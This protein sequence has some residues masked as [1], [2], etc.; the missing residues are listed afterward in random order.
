MHTGKGQVLELILQDG[1]RYARLACPSNLIPSAGQYLLASEG[2]DVSLPFSLFYTD[3]A[4]Q[5]FIAECPLTAPW[6][7]G[8]VLYLRGPLGRGFSL[9]LSAR[10]VGLVAFDHSPARLQGLV[11]PALNQGAAVVL[12]SGST[13]DNLRDEVE[14]QPLAALDDILAWGDYFAIDVDRENL[15]RLREL[16]GTRSPYTAGLGAQILLRTPVPCGGMGECGACA[17]TLRSD[18]KLACKDGPVFD[19]REL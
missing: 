1:R 18:W 19:W 15:N 2:P 4:P 8:S 3:S 9:P 16:L 14:V 7:P 11:Q 12:V 6:T 10:K 13:P 17:V 5:G